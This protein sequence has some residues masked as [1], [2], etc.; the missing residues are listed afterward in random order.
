MFKKIFFTLFFLIII[1][2]G[3][4]SY[5]VSTIDWNNY[6]NKITSQ[7]ENITGK[8]IVILGKVDLSF[9][10]SPHLSATNIKVYNSATKNTNTPIAEI[11]E[12][13]ADLNLMPLLHKKFE[14]EKMSLVEAKLTFEFLNDGKTNWYSAVN[15]EQ[16]FDLSGVDVAFNSVM[17]QNSSVRIIN[18]SFDF[19]E[20]FYKVNAEISAQS[21]IGPFRVDGNFIKENTPAGFALNIGTIS[22]SFATSL[23]LVLTHPSS[24]SYARFDG[25]VLSNNS[26]IKGNFTIESQKPSTFLNTISGQNLLVEKYNYPLASTIAMEINPNQINLSSF[27]IK[28]GD[29]LAGSGR[30][31][32]PLKS[33]EGAKK[34]IETSFEMTDFDLMPFYAILG[35]YLKQY[36]GSNKQYQP[37]F[38]YD[39]SADIMATRAVFNDDYIRNFK[40]N[41][42]VINNVIKINNL[43]GLM[44]GDT[45]FMAKGEI[46]EDEKKL[47]YTFH[48]QSLSQDFL[49]FMEWNNIKPT[50]YVPSTYRNARASFEMSGHLDQI[51]I[52]PF[53]FGMDKFEVTGLIG[54]RRGKRNSVFL[55]LQSD[56]IS[57]DNY[58]PQKKEG[59]KK[60]SNTDRIR[61]FLKQ[62]KFF[63]NTDM[64]ADFTLGTGIYNQT[65]FE[66]TV[67][68]LNAENGVVEIEELKIEK[69]ASAKVNLSGKLSHLTVNPTFE[70]LKYNFEIPDFAL[71]NQKLNL[72]LENVALFDVKNA[73]SFKGIASGTIDTANIKTSLYLDQ[74]RFNYGGRIYHQGDKT[75]Y[76]GKLQ[77]KATD[78]VDFINRLSLD[79]VPKNLLNSTFS[80]NADIDGDLSNW[81]SENIDAFIGTN[82]FNGNISYI[83]K[84][85]KPYVE[86]D[87]TT[88]LLELDR[89]IYLPDSSGAP[90]IQKLKHKFITRPN[91]DDRPLNFD[92]L[93]NFDMKS[94][95][96]IKSLCYLDYTLRNVSFDL[97]VSGND[98]A[99]KNF[100]ASDGDTSFRTDFTIKT[101]ND[102]KIE[103][104][105]KIA[106]EPIDQIGGDLYALNGGKLSIDARYNASVSSV[107]DFI[108]TFS[109]DV[110]FDVTDTTVKGLDIAS[111]A[112]DLSVRTR[113]DGLSEFLEKHLTTNTT[114][115]KQISLNLLFN[116]GEYSITDSFLESEQVDIKV[117]G[118][119]A[120][121]TWKAN[122]LFALRFRDMPTDLPE[123]GFRL[124]DSLANPTFVLQADALKEKYDTHWQKLEEEAKQREDARKSALNEK[125]AHAQETV[126][127]QQKTIRSEIMPRLKRYK[128]EK[129]AIQIAN[130][131]ESVD[132]QATDILKNLE[133]MS[134]KAYRDFSDSDIEQ[135]EIATQTF[136]PVI[137]E[138]IARL[139]ENYVFDLQN[140]II[141]DRNAITALYD[142]TQTKSKNY[143]NTLNSYVLR[144]M[145]MGSLLILDQQ[146]FVKKQK[147]KIESSIKEIRNINQQSSKTSRGVEKE[148]SVP[149]LDTLYGK[150][151][152][153][154]QSARQNFD[155]LDKALEELFLYVKDVVYFEQTGKHPAPQVKEDKSTST[156]EAKAKQITTLEKEEPEA[157]E[158]KEEAQTG[159]R[160]QVQEVETPEVFKNIAPTQSVEAKKII[161]QSQ[162]KTIPEEILAADLSAKAPKKETTEVT[163]VIAPITTPLTEEKSVEISD[164]QSTAENESSVTKAQEEKPSVTEQKKKP[165][166]VKPDDENDY[167]TQNALSGTVTRK[168]ATGSSKTSENTKRSLLRP[169]DG[170]VAI[171]GT[172]VRK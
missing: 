35:E 134:A 115:F 24:E 49:K 120:L 65:P 143:Q 159:T 77:I 38:D 109:G 100:Q 149:K 137:E 116:K 14:I 112:R 22:E 70:N 7:L 147:E 96:S 125:M 12:M 67:L 20:T 75:S 169:V 165:L 81:R 48:V 52:S 117:E 99:L 87:I 156:E 162:E 152:T 111:I 19:D 46:F 42:D 155:A 142:K 164:E 157:E 21:L 68:K 128:S 97:D 27:I 60:T 141:N 154:L 51:K 10:P 58:I 130:A 3:G 98:I 79:Y 30:V 86:A 43:S 57:F 15:L 167:M 84:Q 153:L 129:S 76:Y 132:I 53:E 161:T 118:E 72:G 9:W 95:W 69:L 89:L 17:M 36:E 74:T 170:S 16:N 105:L 124:K 34:K 56:N 39:V 54:I 71:F 32:I 145:Q 113:S 63:E 151:E 135:I 61:D 85:N 160:E 50:A 64:M 80:F 23:N 101:A 121:D 55:S 31:L 41:A 163:E 171:E 114:P 78:F 44:P 123:I 92:V 166:L 66:N 133:Q 2:V 146:E 158:E 172:V 110:R 13:V 25:S 8:K 4:L 93:K 131:Y 59:E 168:G 40:L 29:N 126:E 6:K 119:G 103:G 104:Q 26:E 102:A 18:S 1:A 150:M 136:E 107:L 73:V 37:Q 11:K 28:Y 82:R 140:H 127:R 45:D 94:K 106:N 139:D 62:F 5:Y 138:L 90:K 88:D 91:F 108:K 47:A 148:T 144:L 83:N 122:L 33:K